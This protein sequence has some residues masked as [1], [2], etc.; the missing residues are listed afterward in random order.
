[1]LE[2]MAALSL[3]S[4]KISDTN[5]FMALERLRCMGGF[6]CSVFKVSIPEFGLKKHHSHKFL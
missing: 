6:S 4:L 1:M 2:L 5:D 3:Q